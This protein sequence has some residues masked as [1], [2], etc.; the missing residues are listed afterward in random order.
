MMSTQFLFDD[1]PPSIGFTPWL[2]AWPVSIGGVS[3]LANFYLKDIVSFTMF[4]QTTNYKQIW[5][6]SPSA[7]SFIHLSSLNGSLVSQIISINNAVVTGYVKEITSPIKIV[8][9]PKELEDSCNYNPRQKAHLHWL[10][11]ACVIIWIGNLQ[12]RTEELHHNGEGAILC[13]QYRICQL[14]R[15]IWNLNKTPHSFE[16]FQIHTMTKGI[17]NFISNR[18]ISTP[19]LKPWQNSPF[20]WTIPNSHKDQGDF[21]FHYKRTS[22]IKHLPT[23]PRTQLER[24]IV[25]LHRFLL[26]RI[27]FMILCTFIDLWTLPSTKTLGKVQICC[28][29]VLRVCQILHIA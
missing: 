29:S 15:P 3:H 13:L 27:I 18:L 24:G 22:H 8:H 12:S 16:Q 1:F 7:P 25:K 26:C 4:P 14:T 28:N 17:A 11:M 9:M 20:L 21:Q 10:C 5:S 23:Q 19:H 6:S 2:S